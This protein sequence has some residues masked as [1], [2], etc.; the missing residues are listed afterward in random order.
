MQ[1]DC[2][3]EREH[4]NNAFARLCALLAYVPLLAAAATIS[5][6]ADQPTIQSAIVSAVAGDTVLVS[7]GT[8]VEAIDFLGKN[9][10]LSSTGGP[11]VTTIRAP[12]MTPVVQFVNGEGRAAV[13]DGFTLTNGKPD[14]VSPFYGDGGGIFVEDASPTISNN[15]ITGNVAN[16]GGG[17]AVDFGSPAISGN[18]ISGNR[19]DGSQTHFTGAFQ[20]GGIR[21]SG[22]AG[23]AYAAIVTGN[24]IVGNTS[25]NG[26]GIGMFEAGTPTIAN[27]VMIG[28]SATDTNCASDGGTVWMANFS[29]ADIVENVIASNEAACNGGV[30]FFVPTSSGA[31][32]P[33]LVNNTIALNGGSQSSGISADG[34]ARLVNN[35]VL[36]RPGGVAMSCGNLGVIMP[37]PIMR[38][39]IFFASGGTPATSFCAPQIGMNGNM[40]VDPKL[41]APA[42][43]DFHLMTNSPAIDTGLPTEPLLPALD[44]DGRP[45]IQD[46]NNDGIAVV[47]IGAF[48]KPTVAVTTPPTM[49]KSF[50]TA[51]IPLNGSTTLTFTLSNPDPTNTFNNIGFID[52]LPTG[53]VVASP[54]GLTSTCGNGTITATAGSGNIILTGATRSPDASCTFSVNVTGTTANVKNNTV[55]A[56][57]AEGGAGTPANASLAVVAP[58][59]IAKQFRASSIAVGGSTSLSFTITNPNGNNLS[60]TGVQFTDTL[61]PGLV[62]STPNRLTGVCGDGTISAVAGSGTV[63]L[64]G[65]TLA[66]GA[67]CTFSVN[68]TGGMLGAKNNTTTAVISVEGGTGAT[69]LAS[70][71]VAP[72]TY[73]LSPLD[74]SNTPAGV[75]SPSITVTTPAGCPVTATSYQPWATVNSITPNDDTTTV[76][77]TIS[78]NAGAAR[79]T[80]IRVA[81]RL[82]L[83]TQLGP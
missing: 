61:P 38:N 82:F 52:L 12:A 15:V 39:N 58:P 8:Y 57:S 16:N 3:D 54:N 70:V 56:T 32:G 37:P 51:S 35:V 71:T 41:T 23:V 46:G 20:G 2:V 33:A 30:V 9:I 45:R 49:V 78:P 6:P 43:G 50:A 27:N 69:A 10:R 67:Q 64:T 79:A 44:F 74:L 75:S 18:T 62:V 29:D 1:N 28:N 34:A 14:F 48:E 55:S 25:L 5:V 4:V 81:D 65:A 77:L 80:A 24:T 47:D 53:L 17:I 31:R 21:L 26:S 7:P 83:I 22:A 66:A 59:V 19:A 13:L 63:S 60:V 68:V 76:A 42:S 72:C 36:A 40:A 11:T 73:W